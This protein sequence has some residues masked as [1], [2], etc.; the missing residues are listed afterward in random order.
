MRRIRTVLVKG[1]GLVQDRPYC[2]K[3][4]EAERGPYRHVCC[5][6]SLLFTL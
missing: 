1:L 4:E 5:Y 2:Q 3:K 6:H